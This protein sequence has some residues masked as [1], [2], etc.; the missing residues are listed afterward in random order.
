MDK[1]KEDDVINN[2]EEIKVFF[3]YMKK[4][5]VKS[6]R[7]WGCKLCVERMGCSDFA[8]Y[9]VDTP[10]RDSLFCSKH[11]FLKDDEEFRRKRMRRT[12]KRRLL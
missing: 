8:I 12:F 4:G 11:G 9:R 5:L 6:S 7:M 1:T 3:E 2:K 10:K